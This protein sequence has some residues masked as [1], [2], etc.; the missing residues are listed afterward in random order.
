LH[1]LGSARAADLS[2]YFGID[3]GA[4]SRQLSLLED[5]RL[6]TRETVSSV[7]PISPEMSR[8]VSGVSM[9]SLQGLIPAFSSRVLSSMQATRLST[10]SPA[11]QR[12]LMYELSSFWPTIWRM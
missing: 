7:E 11:I 2:E 10:R 1:D 6:I 9:R 8:L 5:L 4:L 3:K 12:A